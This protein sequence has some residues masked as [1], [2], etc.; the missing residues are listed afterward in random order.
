M[1]KAIIGLVGVAL[2]V[3]LGI[4]KD[5]I[6]QKAK[7]KKEYE[8]L[9]IRVAC[10]LDRFVYRCVDVA[11]DDGT[12]YGQY[13]KDGCAR[14]QVT[15]PEFNPNDLDVDWR[16]LPSNLMYEI[17]NLPNK[18]ETAN[19]AISSIFDHVEGPPYYEEGFEARQ[20]HYSELGLFA[21]GLAKRLRKYAKLPAFEAPEN[22]S[23][24]EM[25]NDKRKQII[26]IQEER[27]RA[28]DK[29]MNKLGADSA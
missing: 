3:L 1:D 17:L 20:L 8:Y 28:Q 7:R 16:S 11:Q 29:L 14:I 13:D 22:W 25:L 26:K 19:E 24:N 18:I 6:F 27:Y 21:M 23:P 9:A 4:L 5:W 15:P 12:S 2:G 10:E